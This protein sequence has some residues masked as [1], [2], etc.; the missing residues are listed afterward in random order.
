MVWM[1]WEWQRFSLNWPPDR[2]EEQTPY[3][4]RKRA[5]AGLPHSKA[6]AASEMDDKSDRNARAIGGL[7]G[8]AQA[9]IVHLWAQS[10]VRKKTEIHATADAEG[11]L[12]GGKSASAETRAAEQGLRERIDFCGVAKS[13][14]RAEEI[15]VGI[16][17][18]AA[19]RGV[20]GAEV[21]DKTEPAIGVIS[22][23]TAHPVLVDAV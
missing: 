9:D 23:R 4:S 19:G 5:A 20:V 14:A 7:A 11:K 10:E 1:L 21:A 12:V 13:Q 6:R 15:G 3:R 2:A 18:N 16:K 8:V 17:G 22:E